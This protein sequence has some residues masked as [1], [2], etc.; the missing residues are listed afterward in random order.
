[1]VYFHKFRDEP[2]FNMLS[3]SLGVGP[4][5]ANNLDDVTLVQHLLNLWLQHPNFAAVKARAGTSGRALVT[6]GI[7]GPK[8][9]AQILLAQRYV[10]SLGVGMICD[11][12]VDKM[13]I[14]NFHNRGF[15]TVYCLHQM[16]TDNH[17][18][19]VHEMCFDPDFPPRLKAVAIAA[20]SQSNVAAGVA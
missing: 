18:V 9:K 16:V 14:A 7:I 5:R 4:R 6:D 13:S 3:V 17:G 15:Y 2:S 12:C 20:R 8:T 19:S 1:M 11:G 10:T